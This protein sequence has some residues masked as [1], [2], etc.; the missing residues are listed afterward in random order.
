MKKNEYCFRLSRTL[1]LSPYTSEKAIEYIHIRKTY[2]L[3]LQ[4]VKET[5][6]D[7]FFTLQT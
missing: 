5:T 1:S 6:A 3:E 4:T 2:F 7:F